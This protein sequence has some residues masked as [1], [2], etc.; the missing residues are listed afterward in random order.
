M[1]GRGRPR[2]FDRE[3]ALRQA[4]RMFWERGYEATSTADLTAAMGIKPPSLY[5]A[6]GSK[7]E[8][9]KEAVALYGKEEG[10][11]T[12]RALGEEGTTACQAIERVLRDNAVVYADP[13]TPPGCMVVLAGTNCAPGNEGV[14]AFLAEDRRHV[15][16]SLRERVERGL[17]DGDVAPGADAERLADFYS[18]V[19]F[20]LSVQSRDGASCE[21][22][23]G[24]VDSAMAAWE[25]LTRVGARPPRAS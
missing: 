9:F 2:S 12:D 6:F 8:L 4:M 15:V 1:A 16:G 13:A 10:A 21:E 18:T 5:A 20:G 7:E 25:G 3:T 11:V 14:Q 23:M 22:L 19:L 17:A 24:V